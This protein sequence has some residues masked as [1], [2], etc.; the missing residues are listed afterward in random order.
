LL[1]ALHQ[2]DPVKVRTKE[3][4][5]FNSDFVLSVSPQQFVYDCLGE[6]A[7][8]GAW[9][10][11]EKRFDNEQKEYIRLLIRHNELMQKEPTDESYREY[12]WY[13]YSYYRGYGGEL[14][15]LFDL[16]RDVVFKWKGSPKSNYIYINSLTDTFRLAVEIH[17]EPEIDDAI[18][19]SVNT[20]EISRFTPS[21]RLGFSQQDQIFLFELDYQL[22]ILLK[23]ISKGYR[24][25]WEEL[26]D[27]LQFS[28][29]HDQLIESAE[30]TKEL[31]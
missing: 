30:K 16:V 12:L 31:L 14:G 19:G 15:E 11:I 25:S 3:T 1:E 18:F 10:N 24:P 22:Y 26:Q 28:E 6:E 13:L 2:I 17:I 21:I 23:Q 20:E 7:F 27:A 29:L 4:D 5:R 8:V 9:R